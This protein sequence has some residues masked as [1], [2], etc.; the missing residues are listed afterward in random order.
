MKAHH[1]AIVD[2]ETTGCSHESDRII[3]VG[4][5]VVENGRV[6]ERFS[7]LV[8]PERPVPPFVLRLTGIREAELARAPVFSAIERDLHA[9]LKD[10]LFVAHNARF[11]YGFL[12]SEF[13][14]AGRK[15]AADSLCTVRLS[16][17]LFPTERRHGVDE[18]IGRFGFS[19]A[20]RHRA[21]DDAEI[22]WKFLQT[23]SERL[24]E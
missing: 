17:R 22:L 4:V 5:F 12:Q 13:Q 20:S 23:A 7:S 1:F 14:R 6:V 19:I 11:D 24:S 3:E 15:F 21:L 8:N 10:R 16:R 9:L 18:L 2:V